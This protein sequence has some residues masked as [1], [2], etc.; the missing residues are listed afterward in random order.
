[1]RVRRLQG[2]ARDALRLATAV[3]DRELTIGKASQTK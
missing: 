1:M 2:V 3:A